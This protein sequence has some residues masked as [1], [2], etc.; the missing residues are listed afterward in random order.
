M[1]VLK[2]FHI[3]LL[4]PACLFII[5][6]LSSLYL[7]W[8]RL[9]IGLSGVTPGERQ[10]LH[11]FFGGR[12]MGFLSPGHTG[13]LFKCLFFSKGQRLEV[14]SFSLINSGYGL[15]I[16]LLLGICACIYFIYKVSSLSIFLKYML[17]RF[18]IFSYAPS[19]VGFTSLSSLRNV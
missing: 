7:L 19:S 8:K 9:I 18:F 10:I 14:T 15:L 3:E 17:A 13:E 16:R 1:P 11:S 2:E 12:T 5:F 6:H 4:F